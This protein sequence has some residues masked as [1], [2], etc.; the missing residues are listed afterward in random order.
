MKSI[1]FA[2]LAATASAAKSQ[3][4][5]GVLRFNGNG[6]LMDCRIDAIVQP[7]G[8]SSHVH[9]FMGAG[10]IG[11]SSTGEE[12]RQSTCTNTQLN[13]DKSAYWFPKLYFK[14]PSDGKLEPVPLYYAAVYYFFE[15]TNDDIKA[16][17]LG[18]QIVSGNAMARTP[19]VKTNINNL[20]PSRGPVSPAVITCPR[21]DPK[22]PTSWPAGSDGS[23]AGI[24]DPQNLGQ[25]IGFPLQV[26]DGLYSPMRVDVHMPSCYDPAAGLT[27]FRSNTA[28]PTDAGNGRQD[29]PKGWVHLP[30]MFFETYWDTQKFASRMQGV[31]GKESP[32]V[33]SNGDTTGFSAHADFIAGWDETALQQIIDNCNVGHESLHTC[34]GLIGGVNSN[35][36]CKAT[37]PV[38]EDVNGKLDKLP[39][40][41]LLS[42]FKYGSGGSATTPD[43]P[44]VNPPAS[45]NST[46]PSVPVES[47]PTSPVSTAVVWET[48]TVWQTTTVYNSPGAAPTSSPS[49]KEDVAGFKYAGCY[50]DAQDRVLAGD[51]LPDIG[52]VTNELCVEHCVAKGFA[53]AGTQYGGECFCGNTLIKADKIDEDK[54]SM[55]CEGG[56]GECGG[57]WALSL[58]TKDGKVP[59]AAVAE[60][61]KRHMHDHMLHHRR[62]W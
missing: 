59:T 54:C 14:D 57:R 9:T 62:S 29:C 27:S 52:K 56:A 58:Y 33:F 26:C 13:A 2:A 50:G 11:W 60:K 38:Q 22:S 43:T 31:V 8:P 39:G 25:G 41:N 18:L 49:T 42:G 10:N 4:T 34:P 15:P 61:R 7:G 40:N 55:A 5:F 36:N 53:A 20:D 46:A 1:I 35:N 37:C 30:H 51:I 3:R 24:G 28:F 16:F 21:K 12:L 23:S 44:V 17:P 19:P 32:F 47:S 45:G 48:V 6:P